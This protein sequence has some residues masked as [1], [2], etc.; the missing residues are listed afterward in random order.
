VIETRRDLVLVGG[1]HTHALALRKL[2]MAPPPGA[3]ITLV[4]DTG[5]APYSG[6]LPGLVAG[7]Y[8]FDDAHIDLRRF[9]T[10][11]GIRF[12]EAAASGIDPARHLVFLEG[13]PPLEYDILSINTGAAPELDSVPGAR[14]FAVPVKPV[15]S[16]YRRWRQLED[17]LAVDKG[18]RVLLVGGGAGSV[19]LALAMRHRLGSAPRIT[20]LCGEQLLTDYNGGARAAVRRRLDSQGI[21]C[22]E[23]NRVSAVSA[24][25]VK[26]GDQTG[27]EYDELVWC[28]GVVPPG[29]L[30]N[31]GLPLDERGFIQVEDTLSVPG[32]DGVFAA[33]DVAVQL[34]HP[35]PR[36]G[37]FAV[38][39]APVL[40]HNLAAALGGGRLREH[41]PQRR[42]LSLLSLGDRLAVADKGLF[43]A[44]GAWVWRWKDRIDRRFMAQFAELPPPMAEFTGGGDMHCGG[45][46]AKLPALLLRGVLA[47]LGAMFPGTV[48]PEHLREDAAVIDWPGGSLV[49]TADTLRALVDD[50]WLMGR[51]VALHALSDIYAMGASPH[52]AQVHACLPYASRV[53][54]QRELFQ[55]MAGLVRELDAAGCQLVGG[56]S[57]EG[58]ELSLGLTVNG[59]VQ[60]ESVLAKT[61]SRPGDRLI[62]TKPLGTGVI[63]AA[64]MSG[65]TPGS[66]TAAAIG[67]MLRSNSAAAKIAMRCASACTDITGF[68]LLGHLAEMLVPGL[69]ARID[70]LPALPGANALLDAGFRS[71]LH[72]GN[73]QSVASSLGD[74]E[75]W[76]PL[77]FDPQ[78]SG[79]LLLSVPEA[80][81][82]DCLSALAAAGEQAAVI[83]SLESGEGVVLGN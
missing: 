75:Q 30:V 2:S 23:N 17:R 63:F 33:G 22:I 60:D 56:H 4:S 45:C 14:N 42:F 21:E 3:R 12:I 29:W 20:L 52:S 8:D 70:S 77:A 65:D 53:L 40:A 57:M 62:L 59:R 31:A 51:L 58:P 1:G 9:C 10:A 71:T 64:A 69:R 37:V 27:L 82:A 78:T 80:G 38:R 49:Q 47:E 79:G 36:A 28:T 55:L 5:F 39:Q 32:L 83:G 73:V 13:R 72:E 67:S 74:V 76:P 7:H 19:E 44:S 61:G 6:M 34:N 46:G 18:L 50:P 25:R 81:V 66:A 24:D 68:G 26:T 43:R 35:R 41:R 11:R 48:V 54:Q 15:G 16:F